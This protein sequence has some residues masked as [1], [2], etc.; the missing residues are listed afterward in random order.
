VVGNEHVA[1]LRKLALAVHLTSSAG[2]LGAVAAYI[3]L[4]GAVAVSQ[5]AQTLRT[6]YLGMELIAGNLIVPLALAS[7]LTGLPIS[8]GTKWGLF[9][10]YWS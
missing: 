5:E 1:V 8:L 7:P 2:W 6:A 10:H 3:A 9:R 4:D